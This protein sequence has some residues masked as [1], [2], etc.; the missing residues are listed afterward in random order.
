ML[1]ILVCAFR[2]G[3][4]GSLKSMLLPEEDTQL[5]FALNYIDHSWKGMGLIGTLWNSRR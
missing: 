2:I 5:L 1:D 4:L 3:S